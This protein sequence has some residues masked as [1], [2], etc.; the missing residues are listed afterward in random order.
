M[1]LLITTSAQD[2]YPQDTLGIEQPFSYHNYLTQPIVIKPNSKI[3]VQSVK[4]NRNPTFHITEG[5]N[6]YGYLN[7]G[8]DYTDGSNDLQQNYSW[9]PAPF[10][11]LPGNYTQ[12][13]L[14]IEIKNALDRCVK[15]HPDLGTPVVN[16]KLD[17]DNN[18]DGF[19][20]DFSQKAASTDNLSTSIS[21]PQ[22]VVGLTGGTEQTN[23][24][25]WDNS[26]KTL[27]GPLTGRESWQTFTNEPLSHMG[28]EFNV[29]CSG[30][31]RLQEDGGAVYYVSP[32]KIG[33]SRPCWTANQK[34]TAPVLASGDGYTSGN[35]REGQPGAGFTNYYKK[36][37]TGGHSMNSVRDVWDFCI[38]TDPANNTLRMWAMF[39]EETA[40]SGGKVVIK[41]I[42]YWKGSGQTRP[43]D[44]GE[45][46]EVI[47]IDNYFENGSSTAPSPYAAEIT[48]IK[49]KLINERIIVTYNVAGDGKDYVLLDGADGNYYRPPAMNQ[50][51]WG[52]YPKIMI[53][54]PNANI[55]APVALTCQITEYHGRTMPTNWYNGNDGN[56]LTTGSY[57]SSFRGYSPTLPQVAGGT[58][59]FTRF[60]DM[61]LDSDYG[62]IIAGNVPDPLNIVGIS[63]YLKDWSW[64]MV[65]GE[66]NDLSDFISNPIP[67]IKFLMGFNN[68]LLD[69]DSTQVTYA[70][71]P[72]S[73]ATINSDYGVKP[74]SHS[75]LFVRVNSTSQISFNAGKTG[76]SKIMY[77]IPQFSNTGDSV[78]SLFFEPAEK[79][80]LSLNNPNEIILNDIRV[81]IVD[82]NEI[83]ANELTGSSVVCF[84]IK[85]D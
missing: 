8:G 12:D 69:N 60:I 65:T 13:G 44:G 38:A 52:L 61:K 16:V 11:I 36:I 63:E 21:D 54:T 1:S 14:A 17:T 27:T 85:D 20:V 22:Y 51:R 71:G 57:Y 3:A 26:T 74:V 25:T 6:Y 23:T 67:N 83:Y 84:H 81:D 77:H 53:G 78:G 10:Q 47:D 62:Q 75:S 9:I 40:G 7:L 37:T 18:F 56:L 31:L 35:M 19:K 80:Y 64:G 34:A 15:Y 4:I 45:D 66:Y 55:D 30:A 32:F 50:N 24:I 49:I 43:D 46:D 68:N 82:K 58:N 33:L 70:A 41:E 79:T 28:G 73:T 2:T 29:N 39:N 5:R 76:I 42:E 48:N 59:T 72:P